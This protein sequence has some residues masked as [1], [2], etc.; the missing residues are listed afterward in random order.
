MLKKTFVLGFTGPQSP[1]T[2]EEPIL[3]NLDF[4][5]FHLTI[6]RNGK[7][8]DDVYYVKF[9]PGKYR[10]IKSLINVCDQIQLKT[11]YMGFNESAQDSRFELKKEFINIF[12]FEALAEECYQKQKE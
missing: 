9:Q 1:N 6:K 12:E 2:K 4:W 11:E 7:K 3:P 8:E 10:K 5:I